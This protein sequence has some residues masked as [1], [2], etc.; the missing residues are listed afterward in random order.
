MSA[1]FPVNEDERYRIHEAA[2]GQTVFSIP[3]PFQAD[4]D[5]QVVKIDAEGIETPLSQPF[6]YTVSG[7]GNP[8]G[9][10]YTLIEPAKEGDRYLNAGAAVMARVVSIVRNGRFNSKA[11]DDDLDRALIR[12]QELARD[13]TRAVKVAYGSDEQALP[14]PEDG[15]V[16][17]WLDG[18]LVNRSLAEVP[19]DVIA[20]TTGKQVLAAETKADGRAA[21][22]A[23]GHVADK[24]AL[25]ALDTSK[26]KVV[27]ME[28]PAGPMR[29]LTGDYSAEVA[30]DPGEGV[31]V[32]AVGQPATAAVWRRDLPFNEVSPK[33]FGA[34]RGTVDD[35]DPGNPAAL[36]SNQ[37]IQRCWDWASAHGATVIMDDEFHG[38]GHLSYSKNL[39][40]K[41]DRGA[42]LYQT[43]RSHVGGFIFGI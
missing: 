33:M 15:R 5:V 39:R 30:A 17:G 2:A 1:V 32:T 3:Y 29:L 23:V 19:A 20:G 35:F 8:L 12:D 16:L 25:K 27:Y 42:F 34:V 40:V 9:G 22:D 4:E 24:T 7:A 37:A 14:P 28:E 38:G 43:E 36:S 31:F 11:I 26:D 13:V 6:D 41:W 21:L 10:S 18:E